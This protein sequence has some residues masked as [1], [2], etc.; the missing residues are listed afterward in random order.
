MSDVSHVR[1]A[2]NGAGGRLR[3]LLAALVNRAVAP[4]SA[5]PV[6]PAATSE[7]PA[8]SAAPSPGAAVDARAAAEAPQGAQ[9]PVTI[10]LA[11]GWH[12]V[13]LDDCASGGYVPGRTHDGLPR[14][15]SLTVQ[16]RTELLVEELTAGIHRLGGS[17]AAAGRDSVSTT[18]MLAAVRQDG[19]AALQ[20]AIAELHVNLLLALRATE[21]ALGKAYRLGHAL[22]ET[23]LSPEDRESLDDAFGPRVVSTKELLAD[24]S[25]SLPSHAARA[26]LLSLRSWESWAADP[27]IDDDTL[28]WRRHGPAVRACLRREGQLWHALLTGEKQ[29]EDML[30][31][32]DYLSAADR[33]VSSSLRAAWVV[34]RRLWWLVGFI[35]LVGAVGV[36][37][38]LENEDVVAAVAA[39][40]GAIGLTG[41]GVKAQLTRMARPLEK[42]LWGAELDQAIADAITIKPGDAG[43]D[44]DDYVPAI[45]EPPKATT[46]LEV[47]ASF[48]AAVKDRR[49]RRIRR[50]LAPDVVLRLQDGDQRGPEKALRWLLDAEDRRRIAT[51]PEQVVGAGPG[52]LVTYLPKDGGADVWRVRE[53]RIKGWKPFAKRDEARASVGLPPN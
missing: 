41:A 14:L 50:L 45:G 39:A 44:S 5:Q 38:L 24:L 3:D 25:S 36:A 20:R 32:R 26:V 53:G 4:P 52:V 23:C 34:L 46:N 13:E 37:L 2:T 30:D 17:F 18:A 42:S 22:A 12:M 16:Q 47:L 51:E 33:L 40:L 21:P 6:L 49:K 28:D 27:R 11:L 43:V 9:S 15:E 29:G 8:A 31:P 7:R 48:R 1:P 10:A 35:A 19:D